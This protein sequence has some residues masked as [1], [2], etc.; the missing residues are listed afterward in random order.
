[1]I[2]SNIV[3]FGRMVPDSAAFPFKTQGLDSCS[4]FFAS[5]LIV[6]SSFKFGA[7]RGTGHHVT[8][9][10]HPHM[11]P[12][13]GYARR[14]LHWRHLS[15][16]EWHVGSTFSTENHSSGRWTGSIENVLKMSYND[17]ARS[18]LRARGEKHTIDGGN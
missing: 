2:S 6:P 8:R 12:S 3:A 10:S 17:S 15:E 5:S 11:P 14:P 16:F 13:I 18:R 1:M 9:L 7:E 4:F